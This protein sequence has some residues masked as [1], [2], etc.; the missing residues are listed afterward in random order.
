MKKHILW[1]LFALL[2]IGLTYIFTPRPYQVHY[3]ANFAVYIDGE[4]VD[5]S[6][7]TYMEETSWCN[8]ATDVRP[9]D[10]IHLHDGKWSL[11]HVHMAASTW[12]DLF[13]NLSWSIG[14]AHLADPYGNIHTATWGKNLYFFIDGKP[15]MNPA[16]EIVKSTDRLLV[17]YGTGS[18]SEIQA[19]ADSLVPKDADEYNHKPDPASCGTNSYWWLSPIILPIMEWKESLP[20]SHE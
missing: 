16:N 10:R 18:E 17:W 20:H 8:V 19:K 5:Y 1:A 4:Q 14:W 11:V 12:G 7:S 13:A 2:A 6:D 9:E 3:H 15:V